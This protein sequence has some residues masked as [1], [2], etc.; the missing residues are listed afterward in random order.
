[1][2]VRRDFALFLK[3][4][5]PIN[6]LIA[7]RFSLAIG[8]LPSQAFGIEFLRLVNSLRQAFIALGDLDMTPLQPQAILSM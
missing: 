7:K 2:L 1:V 8:I 5:H 4:C 6:S 3:F